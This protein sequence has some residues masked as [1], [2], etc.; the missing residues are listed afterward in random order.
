M[1]VLRRVELLEEALVHHG[2]PVAH[3]HRLDLVMRHV[4]RG[5]PQPLVKLLQHRP[6]L[7]AQLGVQ[8]R[9]G[10]VHEED[11]RLACDRPADGDALTLSAGE[12][13]RFSLQELPDAEHLGDLVDP[14]LDHLL[15]DAAQ[16]QAISDVVVHAHV[17]IERVVLKDHGDVAVLRRD[18]VHEALADEDAPAGLLLEPSEHPQRGGL[19]ATRRAHE[20]QEL[21]VAH[22]QVEVVHRD[23][24]AEALRDVVVGDGRHARQSMSQR[25]LP[26]T[27]ARDP[28][29]IRRMLRAVTSRQQL[30]LGNAGGPP[31]GRGQQHPDGLVRRRPDGGVQACEHA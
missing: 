1:Q 6:G 22:R 11:G 2:D 28:R 25:G 19:A 5:A 30:C 3:G 16:P 24:V 8:I 21:R 17:R 12:L 7:D 23:D 15:G 27:L 31:P 20:H 13:L 26:G 18:V 9:E 4:D 29:G 10:L 14:A